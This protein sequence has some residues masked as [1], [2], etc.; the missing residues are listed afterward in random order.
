MYT[1]NS[2]VQPR[3]CIGKLKVH[4]PPR[5]VNVADAAEL[6]NREHK[7]LSVHTARIRMWRTGTGVDMRLAHACMRARNKT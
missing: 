4:G 5:W 2:I 6:M 7:V 3:I 1:T